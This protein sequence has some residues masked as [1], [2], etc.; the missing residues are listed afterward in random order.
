MHV[1]T[2]HVTVSSSTRY[3]RTRATNG[4]ALAHPNGVNGEQIPMIRLR[5]KWLLEHGFI[6]GSSVEITVA[7]GALILKS[8]SLRR[9]GID[10][11]PIEAATA[12]A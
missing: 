11:K 8:E 12:V 10:I 4:K 7:P 1:E 2:R 3:P 6:I 5:G 9:A